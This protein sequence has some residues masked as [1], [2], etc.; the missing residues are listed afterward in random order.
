[1]KGDQRRGRQGRGGCHRHPL[2]EGAAERPAQAGA[3]PEPGGERRGQRQDAEDGGEAELPAD[4]GGDA[5]VDR[6][7]HQ[8][9]HGQPI[10]ARGAPPRERRQHRQRAH[11]AGPLD[12]RPRSGQR[13]VDRDQAEHPEQP[14]PQGQAERGEQW[15]RQERQERHV[16]ATDGE[17]VRQPCPAEVGHRRPVDALVLAED[18]APRQRR[19]AG[20]H[21]VAD[22]ALGPRADAG[23]VGEG[24]RHDRHDSQGDRHRGGTLSEPRFQGC[25]RARSASMVAGP[26][27]LT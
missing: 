5:G 16:L 10:Q 15:H 7:G 8:G 27:P 6:N 20:R 14:G 1:M 22:G 25:R 13:H 26:M 19:L 3:T 24:Q 12:R 4:V 18:E 11:H 21:P 17:Q 23:G 9:R 2:G